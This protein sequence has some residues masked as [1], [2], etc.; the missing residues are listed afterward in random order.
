[1]ARS[2]K[3]QSAGA[4]ENCQVDPSRIESEFYTSVPTTAAKSM[5]RR[6][7]CT[8]LIGGLCSLLLVVSVLQRSLRIAYHRWRM[9]AAHSRFYSGDAHITSDGLVGY[10]VTEALPTY[11]YHRDQLVSLGYFFHV[12]YEFDQLPN[13]DGVHGGIWRQA[14]AAFPDNAHITFSNPGYELQV[15]DRPDRRAAWDSFHAEI[16][17]ADFAERNLE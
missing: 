4:L 14:K 17:V 1:M 3:H 9:D 13:V 6:L 2:L 7:L 15:W 12:Q 16:N 5:K 10:D 11:E 8:I